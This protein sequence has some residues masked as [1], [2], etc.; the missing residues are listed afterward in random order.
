MKRLCFVAI[1]AVIL[2]FTHLG[3]AEAPR[4]GGRLVFGLRNDLSTLNPFIRTQSSNFYIRGLVYEAL[5]D[6]DKDGKQVPALAESWKA[7][8][9]GKTYTFKLRS[10]VKFHDGREMTAADVKWCIEYAMDPENR[11]TGLVPLK[12]VQAVSAADKLTVEIVLK[13]PDATFLSTISSI[14]PFP[15]V[16]KE[17]VPRGGGRIQS[18]PPGTGPFVLKDYKAAREITLARHPDYWQKGLPYLDEIILKPVEDEQVRF[19]SLRAGDLNMIERTPYSFI[20]R[21]VKGEY[22]Q[23]KTAVA[24]YAGYRRLLFN[25]A[26]PPF[27]NVKLRQAVRYALDKRKYI[28]GAFWGLGE[29]TDQL[30]PKDSPW[31]VKLP[32]IK[33]DVA[34]V[35]ALLKE[36]G[37]AD[38][39][40]E[41]LG[42]KSEEEEL[43]VL[44]QLISSAG[45]KTKVTILENVARR[46]RESSGDF[47]IVF[48][49]SD[50]PNDPGE[51]YPAEFGCSEEEVKA[52]K[53]GE[54]SS[55]YCNREFDRLVE[56]AGRI[57]D[58]KRR[59]ELYAKATRILHDEAPEIP[60]ALVPRYYTYHQKFRGFE[61]DSDGRFNMTTSGLSR[62]WVIP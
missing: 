32:E 10:G 38:F 49:G 13:K 39:E 14:R 31:Y 45:I 37:G 30:M 1:L 57:L 26:A 54:N 60:L 35:K 33:R 36:A 61:T 25:V 11:A 8:S 22:P 12:D 40:A 44:Q 59:Y 51:E 34:K 19:A 46:A 24:K 43:Q 29:T 2:S 55:G 56:E 52:K 50:I 5:L 17:S 53:W 9:D 16:P 42:L 62:T 3:A 27:N 7:S 21:I 41:L 6:Y 18:A 48:S 23:L 47:M 4:H 58:S 15:I 28:E 20:S